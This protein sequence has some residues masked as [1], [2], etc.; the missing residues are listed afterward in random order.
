MTVTERMV[1]AEYGRALIIR[2]ADGED[3]TALFDQMCH[4]FDN[5]KIEQ[6]S[7]G[8]VY[9]MAPTGGESSDQNS[10]ITAQLYTWSM[11]D[12][13]G[14]AFDSN[15]LF[16]L[17]D[18]SKFSPDA[19]WVSKE[20]LRTLSKADRRKFLRLVPEFVIELKSLPTTSLT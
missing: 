4:E 14:R 20:K 17:P 11:Q 13:R 10:A 7:K 9:I 16:I 2:P 15:G 1:Y 3:T 18:G 5:T 19:S 6:D 12:S 8:N